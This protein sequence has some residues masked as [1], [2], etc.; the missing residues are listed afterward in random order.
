MQKNIFLPRVQYGFANLLNERTLSL[1]P[2]AQ[3][4]DNSVPLSSLSL[5]FLGPGDFTNFDPRIIKRTEPVSG[6]INFEPNYLPFVEF[7][8]PDFPW[9]LTLNARE[10]GGTN[11][12]LQPWLC[13]IVV[14]QK[15][16]MLQIG[17]S[18][19]TPARLN[20][21]M[22][23]LPDLNQ[24]WAWAHTHI[25]CPEEDKCSLSEKL[26]A[27][28]LIAVSRLLSP[29]R[30]EPNTSY[31]ACLVPTYEAG[32]QA[33]LTGKNAKD[34]GDP[35][36]LAWDV[37]KEASIDL[38]VYY[39]WGFSTG[40]AG[41][42]E[43]LVR[44]L[45][46]TQMT[47]EQIGGRPLRIAADQGNV[48][49]AK[50]VVLQGILQIPDSQVQSQ[51]LTKG[52]FDLEQAPPQ[53]YYG[54]A[55]TRA[56]FSKDNP[57]DWQQQLNLSPNYRVAAGLGVSVI[58]EQQEQLIATA[59]KRLGE[60]RSEN[61]LVAQALL[62]DL[63]ST[64]LYQRR[65]LDA[66]KAGSERM[67]AILTQILFRAI[68]NQNPAIPTS[69]AD[70]AHQQGV[71][72]PSTLSSAFR[73]HA[74]PNSLIGRRFARAGKPLE[75]ADLINSQPALFKRL[76][77]PID[78]SIQSTGFEQLGV[79]QPGDEFPN[80]ILEIIG[81]L[82]SALTQP[83][84][85]FAL[86]Q[87]LRDEQVRDERWSTLAD[88]IKRLQD[89]SNATIQVE[90]LPGD[91]LKSQLDLKQFDPSITIL[92]YLQAK[93][94]KNQQVNS[95]EELQ[96][97]SATAADLEFS[98]AMVDALYKIS[99]ET[100]I[101]GIENLPAESITILAPNQ[102]FIEAFM[103]GLN[104]AFHNELLWRDFPM[105]PGSPPQ[106]YFQY[107]WQAKVDENVKEDISVI[108]DWNSQSEL[109]GHGTITQL[110]VVV[111][112][113]GALF[114]RYPRTQVYA[115]K[116]Q[117]NAGMRTFP[118]GY[119]S[120]LPRFMLSFPPDLAL[121]GLDQ[122]IEEL[123]GNEGNAGYYIVLEQPMGDAR[124]GLDEPTATPSE[125]TWKENL[126]SRNHLDAS[127]LGK[128][129]GAQ[130]AQYL[131]QSPVRLVIHASQLL[132]ET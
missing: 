9:L 27:Q 22:D 43:S 94:P 82:K 11:R 79:T 111:V 120:I 23:N 62:A 5:R 31:Y 16:A 113:R 75:M 69:I 92:K 95:T 46:P 19:P 100:L 29:R 124:F 17:N 125:Q 49:A 74:S 45:K 59:W 37:N 110:P 48:T 42:F 90:K 85:D 4:N 32:R 107:F 115:V 99:P 24:A 50:E 12:H 60:V 97:V 128:D 93:L 119:E 54:S 56:D 1:Q 58:R 28:S 36:M 109:G 101:P 53:P 33:G 89:Q 80:E 112:L 57:P 30:L 52:E 71:A 3:I 88:T 67:Q 38:P 14:E 10:N 104:H 98:E 51:Q 6:A 66:L 61:Q 83:G 47:S 129:T 117:M 72:M 76:V 126:L 68:L 130:V 118:D 73:R 96:S 55:Y 34:T 81:N 123:R 102:A 20:I 21:R 122:S 7:S 114:Q 40:P 108:G 18:A 63:V 41:D 70:L 44:Q 87:D 103:V 91:I 26:N 86:Y 13:L 105:Q 121:I 35:N 127:R 64:Q 15:F 84:A 39:H 116:A 132:T 2:V 131:Y 78:V 8:R 106:T 25:I 65:L 77:E